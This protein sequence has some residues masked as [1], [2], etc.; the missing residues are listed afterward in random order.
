MLFYLEVVTVADQMCRIMFIGR[1]TWN[2]TV[3]HLAACELGLMTCYHELRKDW[4]KN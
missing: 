2:T 3:Q 4:T 1:A